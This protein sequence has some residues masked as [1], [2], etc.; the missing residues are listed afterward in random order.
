MGIFKKLFKKKVKES[1]TD[2][3]F[4]IA[5][6]EYFENQYRDIEKQ[7]KDNTITYYG[8]KSIFRHYSLRYDPQNDNP[9]EINMIID[10]IFK[11]LYNYCIEKKIITTDITYEDF[12]K[13]KGLY[14]ESYPMDKKFNNSLT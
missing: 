11:I 3:N 4:L 12:Y 13:G 2:N 6:K 14:D 8:A 5:A 1:N 7:C 10:K 9:E